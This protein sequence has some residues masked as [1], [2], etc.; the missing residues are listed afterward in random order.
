[1][2]GLTVDI[3][4]G[5]ALTRTITDL[6]VQAEASVVLLTDIGGNILAQA[7]Q[8]EDRE[9]LTIAALGAGAFSATRE[10][11]RLTGETGFRSVSH[12]GEKTSLFVHS[13][14]G[15]FLLIV[16][17]QRTTTLG[18]VKLYT[19]QAATSLA[20]MLDALRQHSGSPSAH[21]PFTLDETHAAVFDL[22][23]PTPG[24]APQRPVTATSPMHV[25]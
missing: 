11:A 19:R 25:R 1:M 6:L 24:Y 21:G 2:I 16:L 4:Q 10:L 9:L 13:L 12:E 23:A 15:D 7:P 17:F 18:L 5:R 20:T 8:R 3:E 14:D 22:P